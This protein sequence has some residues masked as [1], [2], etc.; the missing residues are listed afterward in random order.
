MNYK[1]ILVSQDSFFL[2]GY[3]VVCTFASIKIREDEIA[4]KKSWRMSFAFGSYVMDNR[5]IH[6]SSEKL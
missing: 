2:R 3:F 4:C 1:G 5:C 6:R